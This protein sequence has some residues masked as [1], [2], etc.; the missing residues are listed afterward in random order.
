MTKNHATLDQLRARHAWGVVAEI[1][2]EAKGGVP[3][4][5]AREVKRLPVRIRSAGLGQALSFLYAKSDPEGHDGRGRIL[6]CMAEWL[7]EERSLARRSQRSTDRNAVIHAIM[8][9]N[10]DLLRRCTEE[11]LSYLQWLSRFAEAE[12]GG[13]DLND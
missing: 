10:A 5:F 4:D 3:K 9:G 12:I 7:L 6:R 1:S 11:A 8:D 2:S 13:D